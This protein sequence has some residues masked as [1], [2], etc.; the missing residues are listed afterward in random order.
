MRQINS[1]HQ[2]ES[3]RSPSRTRNETSRETVSEKEI[4]R[5]RKKKR[6]REDVGIERKETDRAARRGG[7]WMELLRIP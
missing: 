4:E 1:L 6:V 3:R 7:D 2:S 5:G